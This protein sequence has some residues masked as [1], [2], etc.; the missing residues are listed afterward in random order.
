MKQLIQKIK[1]IRSP[2]VYLSDR[3]CIWNINDKLGEQHI[4][5]WKL[6]EAKNILEDCRLMDIGFEGP[7]FTWVKIISENNYVKERLDRGAAN[8]NW[9][10]LFLDAIIENQC[11]YSS[12]HALIS[13]NLTPRKSYLPRP[14]KFEWMWTQDPECRE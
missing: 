3:N 8:M 12:D 2:L 6:K 4:P 1:E 10:A 9:L 5:N 13:L 7:P 14:F 11:P